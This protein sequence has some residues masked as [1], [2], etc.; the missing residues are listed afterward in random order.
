LKEGKVMAI[1]PDVR[2]RTEALPIEFLG[3][4][5]NIGAGMALFARQAGVPIFP[6]ILKRVGWTRHVWTPLEPVFPAGESDKQQD[7]QRM[8]QA[9]MTRFDQAICESPEQYFWYN[10]RWVLDPL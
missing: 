8:T 10:K 4:E 2:A 1:L 6:I 5:A 7:W 3:R 9:V